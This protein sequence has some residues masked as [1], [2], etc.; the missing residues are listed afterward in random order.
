MYRI[1]KYVMTSNLILS[2]LLFR[3]KMPSKFSTIFRK[4]FLE[5]QKLDDKHKEA[6]ETLP[7]DAPLTTKILVKHRRLIG[8]FVQIL[9]LKQNVYLRNLDTSHRL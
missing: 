4:Y 6:L 5:G 1:C 9:E 8:N 2:Y 7:E 3:K